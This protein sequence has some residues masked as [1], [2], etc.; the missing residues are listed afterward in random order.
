MSSRIFIKT[1][2]TILVLSASLMAEGHQVDSSKVTHRVGVNVRPSYILPTHSFFRGDNELGKRLDKSGSAHLQYS[3]SFPSDSRYGK[4]YPT[5][6]QGIGVA[7]NTFFDHKE[8]GDPAAV[9]VFQG[10]RLAQISPTLSLDYEWNFGVSFGWH[11][12]DPYADLHSYAN[13]YNVVVGSRVNAYINFGILLSW[14]P[15]DNWTL[16]AGIDLTHFSNGNTS[17]PNAGVNTVGGRIGVSRSFGPENKKFR[18]SAS[19]VNEYASLNSSRFADRM[20][21]DILLYGAGR[22]KG[23]MWN[24]SPYIAEGKFGILG[25]NISPLYRVN[26]FFRAGLSLDVQYDE[27]ANVGEHVAGIGDDGNIRFYR[28]PLNEQL[29]VGLSIRA[30]FVMPIFSVN[31]GFGRNVIYKGDELKGFYQ[32]LALKTDLYRNLFLHIGY[33]LHDFHD[34][35]NLMLGFGWRF[36]GN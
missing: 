11:P 19:A 28:P 27:S 4:L 6:Y 26:K 7:F 31:I 16:S 18:T 17:Y 12:Y 13:E 14:K 30:E 8:I 24:D 23:L 3:F 15:V 5:A 1:I 21:Y 25:L 33:K 35:N 9:Y 34:P 36:G 29:G 10:A 22:A 20:T 2:L 32:T